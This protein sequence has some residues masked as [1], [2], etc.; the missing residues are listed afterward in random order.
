LTIKK[1]IY[2][3]GKN[4]KLFF[5]LFLGEL[6]MYHIVEKIVIHEAYNLTDFANDAAL[7]FVR[8]VFTSFVLLC[9]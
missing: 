2:F 9:T 5:F 8:F 6:D 3:V 7:I 1:F 4:N